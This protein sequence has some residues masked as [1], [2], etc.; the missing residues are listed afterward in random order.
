M[1]IESGE[2]S[3]GAAHWA[4]RGQRLKISDKEL[5]SGSLCSSGSK[6]CKQNESCRQKH[7]AIKDMTFRVHTSCNE[8]VC[9]DKEAETICSIIRKDRSL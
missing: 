1:K 7:F 5:E 6:P 3:R 9:E 2:R 8:G 4:P